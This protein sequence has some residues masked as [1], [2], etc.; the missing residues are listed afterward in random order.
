MKLV[1]QQPTV[2][3]IGDSHSAS[4]S[5][6]LRPILENANTNIL[7]VSTGWCE[8][9]SNDDKNKRCEE[10]N[11]LVLEKIGSLKPRTVIVNSHWFGASKPPYYIGKGDFILHLIDYLQKLKKLGVKQIFI[12]GQ[13]PTWNKSLPDTLAQEFVKKDLPIPDRT[14]IGVQSESLIMDEVMRFANYPKGITYLSVKDILCDKFG[15][16]TSIGPNLEK[17]LVV[18]DYGHLTQSASKFVVKKLFVDSKLIQSF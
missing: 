7:Q 2:F 18:W 9:T 12:V 6:G 3:L 1:F 14:F 11:D 15:C 4:L 8:P 13:I 16:L 10:I 17:D 5:L